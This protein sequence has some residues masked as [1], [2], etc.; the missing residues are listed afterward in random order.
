MTFRED[1][2]KRVVEIR[3]DV[4]RDPGGGILQNK[5]RDF[6]L[7]DPLLNLWDGIRED[8]IDYFE[9]NNI[10][11]WGGS[12]PTGHLLSSQIACLNHL[13]FLRQRRDI[14]T[15]ILREVRPDIVE[16]VIVDDGYVEFE[17][18]GGLMMRCGRNRNEATAGAFAVAFIHQK[19]YQHFP[20]LLEI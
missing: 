12:E 8:A 13:Y 2:R 14:A 17:V 9:R 3:N 4:F 18:I 5:E 15:V 7:Q 1:E 11:W 19:Y 6:V 20:I 16:A 10:V